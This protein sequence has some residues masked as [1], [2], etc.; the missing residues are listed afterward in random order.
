MRDAVLELALHRV[1]FLNYKISCGALTLFVI[2]SWGQAQQD[3]MLS[4]Y[5][6]CMGMIKQHLS[7]G[8]QHNFPCSEIC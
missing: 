7:K 3:Q 8:K 1:C 2:A 4:T 5:T 6:T